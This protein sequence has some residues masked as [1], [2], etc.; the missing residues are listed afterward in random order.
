MCICGHFT[1]ENVILWV[2]VWI[3]VLG[4]MLTENGDWFLG[5]GR[6]VG[7]LVM[8]ECVY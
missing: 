5:Y 8:L 4:L 1:Y 3:G 6:M 2:I 7:F